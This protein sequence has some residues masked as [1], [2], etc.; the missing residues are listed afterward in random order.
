MAWSD[1]PCK[2]WTKYT[3]GN[4]YGVRK[5][6]GQ[7]VLVHREALAE[8]LGRPVSPG[9][10]ACHH[11]D[12]PA[13]YEPEHL[14]EGTPAANTQDMFAKGRARGRKGMPKCSNG[15]DWTPDNTMIITSSGRTIRQCMT[16]YVARYTRN[17]AKRKAA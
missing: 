1:Y 2:L 6:Q 8:K 3:N 12:T 15:H 5:R 16:C 10:Y 14:F 13:C 7:C 17:N 11:C 4:G 9:L